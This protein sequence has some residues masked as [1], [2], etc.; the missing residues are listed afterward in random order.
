[1]KKLYRDKTATDNQTANKQHALPLHCRFIYFWITF[2]SILNLQKSSKKENLPFIHLPIQGQGVQHFVFYCRINAKRRKP[3]EEKKFSLFIHKSH[4]RAHSHKHTHTFTCKQN[5]NKKLRKI[6]FSTFFS[7][8]SRIRS[9]VRY[10]QSRQ[11]KWAKNGI[12]LGHF[13]ECKPTFS[14]LV[15]KLVTRWWRY[16]C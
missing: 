10:Y 16:Q 5:K 7:I 15:R 6:P 11:R 13:R 9:F 4:N 3:P 8:G 14:R 1:M 2:R 12:T